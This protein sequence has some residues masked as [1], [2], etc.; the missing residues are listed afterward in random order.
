MRPRQGRQRLVIRWQ[1]AVATGFFIVATMFIRGT[2]RLAHHDSGV[3]LDSFAVA[4]VN[5]QNGS[6]D[7]ARIRRAI[8]RALEATRQDQSIESASASTG[9]PFGQMPALQVSI[10]NL[11]AP[12]RRSPSP[13]VA[14]AT[15]PGF[16]RTLGISIVRGRGSWIP[17]ARQSN[18]KFASAYA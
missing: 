15:T 1:V 14:L 6:L 2:I 4:T 17:A 5:F 10:A 3:E 7:E 11:E 16:F 8:D 13:I 18:H 12:E 9:L